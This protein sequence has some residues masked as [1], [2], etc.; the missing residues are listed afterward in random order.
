MS[1][2]T[3]PRDIDP[4]FMAPFLRAAIRVFQVQC[5]LE[6]K[7]GKPFM[8]EGGGGKLLGRVSGLIPIESKAFSGVLAISMEDSVFFALVKS[9]FGEE[10]S[11]VS[12]EN[13]DLAAELAN[14]ILGQ[15]KVELGN[16]GKPVGMALPVSV[17]G[18]EHGSRNLGQ[19]RCVV[20]PFESPAGKI[21]VEIVAGSSA[22]EHAA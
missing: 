6:L 19:G 7:A 3:N 5:S 16:Q 14:M 9:L 12:A 13:A 1:P 20:I 2:G 11:A 22:S 8:K 15:A 21:F 4:Q 17:W 18:D 10:V